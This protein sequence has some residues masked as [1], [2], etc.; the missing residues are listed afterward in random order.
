MAE[1]Y[2]DPNA[3]HWEDVTL[4]DG[5][6]IK[7]PF[8]SM[9]R[10]MLNKWKRLRREALALEGDEADIA[11]EAATAFL[12]SQSLCDEHGNLIPQEMTVTM[13]SGY[14]EAVA[15]RVLVLHKLAPPANKKEAR[16]PNE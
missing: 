3:M 13:W 10:A 15:T 2:R 4:P 11:E 5:E 6:T 14:A 12:L 16:G 8:R 7:L 1:L 9:S